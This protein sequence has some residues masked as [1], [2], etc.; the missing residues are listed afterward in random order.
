MSIKATRKE[1]V[2]PGARE[3]DKA[4]PLLKDYVQLAESGFGSLR[5]AVFVATRLASIHLSP[6]GMPPFV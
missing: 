1:Q 3:R 5:V 4:L 2:A 6:R